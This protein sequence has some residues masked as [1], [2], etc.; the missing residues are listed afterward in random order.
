MFRKWAAVLF[1]LLVRTT[2]RLAHKN[3]SNARSRKSDI[4]HDW[5]D[6]YTEHLHGHERQ[7]VSDIK[8]FVYRQPPFNWLHPVGFKNLYKSPA[9]VVKWPCVTPSVQLRFFPF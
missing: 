9:R 8:V 1:A 2:A 6:W 3:I 7:F 5:I 4:D